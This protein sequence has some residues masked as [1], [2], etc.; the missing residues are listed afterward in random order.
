DRGHVYIVYGPPDELEA[1]PKGAQGQYPR[2][3]WLYRHVEG[4]GDKLF[5]RFVDRTGTGDYRLA[6]GNPW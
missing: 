2:Q 5:I 4:V 1:H 6:P 3:D